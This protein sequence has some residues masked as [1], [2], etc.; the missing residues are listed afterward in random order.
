VAAATAAGA[1][2]GSTKATDSPTLRPCVTDCLQR[3]AWPQGRAQK[4]KN[5]RLIIFTLVVLLTGCKS[6]PTEHLHGKWTGMDVMR[7][8]QK[9]PFE[10][11]YFEFKPDKSFDS[12]M[13]SARQ[14]GTYRTIGTRKVEV[15]NQDGKAVEFLTKVAGDTLVLKRHIGWSQFETFTLV[16]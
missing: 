2:S 15:I 10:A 7:A 14:Y 12:Q 5:M 11:F 1:T 6:G 13:G 8:D 3:V 4:I 16:R 9:V